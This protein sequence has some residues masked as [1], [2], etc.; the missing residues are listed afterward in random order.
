MTRDMLVSVYFSK[1]FSFLLGGGFS[2][3]IFWVKSYKL[4]K[5][6]VLLSLHLSMGAGA[7]QC[8]F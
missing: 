7:D 3:V 8:C 6:A 2:I 5:V 4:C 1:V